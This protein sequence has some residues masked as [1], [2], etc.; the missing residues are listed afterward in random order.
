MEKVLQ[1]ST[2]SYVVN[3]LIMQM[4]SA[5]FFVHPQ[6]IKSEIYLVSCFLKATFH[7]LSFQHFCNP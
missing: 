5:G 6:S 7:F 2:T 1:Q 4:C 3:N